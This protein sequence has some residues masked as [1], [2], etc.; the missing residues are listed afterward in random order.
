MKHAV[1]PIKPIKTPRLAAK[2]YATAAF[3]TLVITIWVSYGGAIFTIHAW[4][5]SSIFFAVIMSVLTIIFIAFAFFL[6]QITVKQLLIARVRGYF[7]NGLS[8]RE[9]IERKS[10]IMYDVHHYIANI[11]LPEDDERRKWL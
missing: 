4:R 6:A 3:I 7:P 8:A 1:H 2:V 10:A 5:H 11:V 9:R